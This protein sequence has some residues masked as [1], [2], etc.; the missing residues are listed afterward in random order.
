MPSGHHEYYY[1]VVDK[2]SPELVWSCN[3][4]LDKHLKMLLPINYLFCKILQTVCDTLQNKCF[5]ILDIREYYLSLCKMYY[6]LLRKTKT[7]RHLYRQVTNAKTGG[8]KFK[9]VRKEAR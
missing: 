4:K 9:G 7:K 3:V 2:T 6:S 5:I 1:Q 8:A